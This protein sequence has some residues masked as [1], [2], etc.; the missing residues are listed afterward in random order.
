MGGTSPAVGHATLEALAGSGPRDPWWWATVLGAAIV[1]PL[2]EE[3]AFRGLLQQGL[4]SAGFGTR[5]AIVLTAGL[6]AL[7]HWTALTDGARASGLAQLFVLAVGWGMLTERSG[8]I[9]AAA[10]AHALFN[11][12]N[13]VIAAR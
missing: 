5:T 4:K 8:R 1:A 3:F 2:A 9:W 12:A 6:F 11:A 7:V 10:I 13:L